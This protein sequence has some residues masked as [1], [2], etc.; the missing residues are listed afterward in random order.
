MTKVRRIF[1][2]IAI[3]ILTLVGPV[4]VARTMAG[5]AS[6][7]CLCGCGAPT[8]A[9]CECPANPMAPMAPMGPQS[10]AQPGPQGSGGSGCSTT[11][12]PCSSR[13][14]PASAGLVEE[15]QDEK[16]QNSGKRPEPKPWPRSVANGTPD[17]LN[18]LLNSSASNRYGEA[19]ETQQG[20]PLDRL[21]K[22]AVFRI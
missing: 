12:T 21:A 18:D 17:L 6:M 1:H 3:A 14:S 13:I 5:P 20:R 8:D 9:A 10:A 16:N 19:S 22:L 2:Y 4:E 11:S 15:S 7:A